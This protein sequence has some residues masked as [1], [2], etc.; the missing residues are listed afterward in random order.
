MS[1]AHPGEKKDSLYVIQSKIRNSDWVLTATAPTATAPLGVLRL[2]HNTVDQR[3][4]W[5]LEEN[6]RGLVLRN[7]FLDLCLRAGKSQGGDVSMAKYDNADQ[8]FIW[9]KERGDDWGCLHKISDSEQ[10]LNVGGNGPYNENTPIIQYEYDKG[11]DHELWK[12]VQY[13]PEFGPSDITYDMT[14]RTLT[15]GE[16]VVGNATRVY[17]TTSTGKV[18]V[19]ATVSVSTQKSITHSVSDATQNTMAV[20]RTFGAKFSAE[21]VFEVSAGVTIT[22]TRSTGRTIGDTSGNSTTINATTSESITVE[23]GKAYDVWLMARRCTLTIPYTAT[24]A[25][26]TIAGTPGESYPISGTYRYE[27]AYRYDVLAAD[28]TDSKPV[29]AAAA[30]TLREGIVPVITETPRVT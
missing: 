24:I 3:Q 11:S 4:L 1:D 6:A 12:L 21:K 8:E 9:V 29:A 28:V 13:D 18:V 16:P 7:P 14:K 5:R 15:L 22:E 19:T 23:P 26:K 17:N 25:R 27:N 30:T 2:G 10:K 20:A